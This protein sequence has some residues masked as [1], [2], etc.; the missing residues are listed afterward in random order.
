MKSHMS[1]RSLLKGLFYGSVAAFSLPTLE[2]FLNSHATAFADGTKL[3]QRFVLGWWGNGTRVSTWVP[4]MTGSNYPLSSALAPY[5]P[6]KDYLNV[7][8]GTQC[9]TQGVVHHAGCAGMLTGKDPLPS[10]VG[11]TSTLAGPTIDKLIAKEIGATT[12]LASLELGVLAPTK[13]DEGT[14]LQYLS[15]DGPNSPNPAEYSPAAVFKRLFG[16]NPLPSTYGS[17]LDVVADDIRS[18]QQSVSS[19]DKARL[20]D[21][22]TN[23]RSIEKQLQ[24]GAGVCAPPADPGLDAAV[25]GDATAVIARGN[26]MWS[27]ISAAFSCDLTRVV[28]VHY[29]GSS[30]CT[31]LPQDVYGATSLYYGG[32]SNPVFNEKTH[33]M[34]HNESTFDQPVVA[35]WSKFYQTQFANLLVKMKA[36]QDSGTTNLLDNSVVMLATELAEGH[37]HSYRHMPVLLAG[38]AGGRLRYPGIHY[39]GNVDVPQLAPQATPAIPYTAFGDMNTDT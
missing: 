16:A 20:E 3:P 24:G 19:A 17:V 14:T 38:K 27:L 6:V 12:R 34:T 7:I 28:S 11:T 5:A 32:S 10:G 4:S 36:T 18:L 31:V 26:L 25:L 29:S 13:A 33:G 15:H 21:Y 8:S 22:F 37:T 23:I 30:D 9:K 35:L 39:A 1:R 2:M